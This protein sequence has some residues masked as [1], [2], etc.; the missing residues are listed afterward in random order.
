MDTFFS[1]TKCDRC[2]KELTDG[3]TMSMFNTECICL[4]CKRKEKQMD[5]YTAA[6]DAENAAVRRGEKNFSGVGLPNKK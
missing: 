6:C 3:R 4:G 2:G 5:E 1:Q